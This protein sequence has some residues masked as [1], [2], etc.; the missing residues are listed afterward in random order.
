MDYA[1][2]K[3]IIES[4]RSIYPRQ[5]D[6]TPISDEILMK[7]LEG[8]RWAPNH[9]ITEPWRF[10][11]IT[12]EGLFRLSEYMADRYSALNQGPKFNE[13]KFQKT[14]EKPLQSGAVIAICMQRDMNKSIPEWEEIAAVSCAVQNM[15][16]LAHSLGIGAYWSSPSLFIEENTFLPLE[17][18]ERVLGMMYM[19]NYNGEAVQ[20]NPGL[21]RDK[22]YWI[23]A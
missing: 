2:L 9:K 4:R 14:K 20:R 18:G 3:N 1:V 11:V 10:K 12:G 7:I 16:L 17:P 5:F 22:L 19:G 8:A 15:W 13:R 23:R 21:I 6:G